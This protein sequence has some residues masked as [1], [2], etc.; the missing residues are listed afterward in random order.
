MTGSHLIHD[1]PTSVT[2][3]GGYKLL[4][5]YLKNFFSNRWV[6]WLVWPCRAKGVLLIVSSVLTV[7]QQF[8]LH[9]LLNIVVLSCSWFCVVF[10]CVFS[11]VYEHFWSLFLAV[12]MVSC[13][14]FCCVSCWC[15]MGLLLYLFA[16]V[17]CLRFLFLKMMS[18]HRCVYVLLSKT[19]ITSHVPSH[20]CMFTSLDTIMLVLK[21][22]FRSTTQYCSSHSCLN[23]STP[24][25]HVHTYIFTH[26]LILP[27][28]FLMCS[29]LAVETTLT[30]AIV[31]TM[32]T[33]AFP[34]PSTMFLC[35]S[36]LLTTLRLPPLPF[37][38]VYHVW[39]AFFCVFSVFCVF[40]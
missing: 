8:F 14:C 7:L 15:C 3:E 2:A 31:S 27:H 38:F 32:F 9:I 6:V 5:F 40:C 36:W 37:T 13:C 24:F 21:P 18:I 11:I 35:S 12:F 4:F 26:I 16:L 23:H 33:H 19:T 30:T 17:F 20:P 29:F 25:A 34:H 28:T 22:I 39:H 10:V 1:L